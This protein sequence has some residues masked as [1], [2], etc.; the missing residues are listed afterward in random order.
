VNRYDGSVFETKTT[1]DGL[2]DNRVYAILE[3]SSG[4][5]WFATQAGV[6]R[7]D[8]EKFSNF[9]TADGLVHD[10]VNG[11][12]EASDGRIWMATDGGV[13]CC[14]GASFTNYTVEKNG[15]PSAHRAWDCPEQGRGHM[16]GYLRRDLAFGRRGIQDV[17]QSRRTAE[18][19][20]P[21]CVRG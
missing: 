6:S 7:Y 15:I 2:V 14:D 3:D 9:T 8:G 18:R 4:F 11:V 13:S 21:A 10:D 16:G 1:A 12:I 5:L 20:G 17:H 19:P